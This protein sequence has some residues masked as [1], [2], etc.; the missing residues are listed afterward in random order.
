MAV[1]NGRG[2]PRDPATA[3]RWIRKSAE[4]GY[5]PA[6]VSLGLMYAAG[7][8]VVADEKQA[9]AWYQKA[10][11]QGNASGQNN[12]G[13]MLTNGLGIARDDARCA[14]PVPAC[15]AQEQR[16]R[17]GQPR[18]DGRGRPRPGRRRGAEAQRW[19]RLAEARGNAPA[20][21]HLALLYARGKG[22]TRDDVAA[23]GGFRAASAQGLAPARHNLGF[24]VANGLGGVPR[25]DLAA[26]VALQNL[27]RE[28]SP[29]SP[30]DLPTLD[31]ARLTPADRARSQQLLTAFKSNPNLLAVLDSMSAPSGIT[32]LGAANANPGTSGN[33]TDGNTIAPPSATQR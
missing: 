12:L 15:R 13:W 10:A 1:L 26:G 29:P 19:Y 8:A 27:A 23:V 24:M 30:E 16:F 28:A 9:V 14:A 21:N 2:T 20:R 17:D 25:A 22:V 5:A 4:S 6:Q 3:E 33:G 32:S 7:D 18:L 31:P 11:A